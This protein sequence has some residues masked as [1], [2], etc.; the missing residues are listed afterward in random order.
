MT[1]IYTKLLMIGLAL[2]T[3]T[4]QGFSQCDAGQ[5]QTTT[6]DTVGFGETFIITTINEEIP[7]IPG[8]FGWIFDNSN[9]DGEGGPGGTF[10]LPATNSESYNSDLAGVLSANGI[11]ALRGTWVLRGTAFT[12]FDFT[13]PFA[14]VCSTTT[15]SLLVTFDDS[16]MNMCSA[17]DLQ[18]T[19]TVEVEDGETF[20]LLATNEVATGTYGYTFDNTNTDG[21][22]SIESAFTV[23]V[24]T[25]DISF[26][27]NL[28]GILTNN[29]LPILEGTWVVRGEAFSD[30]QG[31]VLCSTTADSLVVIFGAI[32][33]VC[34]SGDLLTTGSVTLCG[35]ETIAVQAENFSPPSGGGFGYLMANS[36]TGGTGALDTDFLLFGVTGMDIIDASIG[37][38]LPDNGLENFQGTWVLK[39]VSFSNGGNPALTDICA[40]SQD[41]LIITFSPELTLDLDND[42]NTQIIPNVTGGIRPLSF[43]WSNGETTPIA[44][45]LEDGIL[46]LTVTDAAGCFVESSIDLQNTSVEDIPGLESFTFSPNPTSGMAT[47]DFTLKSEQ[48]MIIS[49]Q[50]LD[51]R[52]IETIINQRTTG[53]VYDINM[54]DYNSGMYLLH[55][56]TNEAQYAT[57]IL[58]Q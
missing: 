50:S 41:S 24:Q 55:I 5:L 18:T 37:G 6:P 30:E 35:D 42:G 21:T 17:G 11:P 47:L 49:I 36:V 25:P 51:G 15:D 29:G 12:D 44:T 7:P 3:F 45:D 13:M 46:T 53:G 23:F 4:Q 8:G 20:D 19:G 31:Q 28:G 14:S 57:R 9:T 56:N 27:N 43:A 1:K 40:V 2:F 22:G 38:L 33:N 54:S 34:I 58:K 48:D 10:I 39:S 16:I 26:D 32:S 52:I